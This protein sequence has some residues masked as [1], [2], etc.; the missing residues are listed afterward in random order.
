[1]LIM[2]IL[3]YGRPSGSFSEDMYIFGNKISEPGFFGSREAVSPMPGSDFWSNDTEE[4]F[5]PDLKGFSVKLGDSIR[6]FSF[7]SSDLEEAGV[8]GIEMEPEL[9]F[10]RTLGH[11]AADE[12][13]LGPKQVLESLCRPHLN[14][15]FRL[16]GW[17]Q[18]DSIEGEKPSDL[19]C[20]QAIADSIN[21]S[22]PIG[23]DICGDTAN[24]HWSHW[25]D[26]E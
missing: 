3:A 23:L 26:F 2:Q 16:D 22:E 1:M 14:L 20:F 19:P 4:R 5:I 11:H 17:R 21:A 12:V 18:P 7:S 24:T 10:I 6:E 9:T 15:I 13:M 8:V 25:T